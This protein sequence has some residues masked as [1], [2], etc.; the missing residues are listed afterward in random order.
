MNSTTIYSSVIDE[1]TI[2]KTRGFLETA[3]G[4]YKDPAVP[5]VYVNNTGAGSFGAPLGTIYTGTFTL[6]FIV[7]PLD[8]AIVDVSTSL[9][10]GGSPILTTNETNIS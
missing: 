2:I 1:K 3:I 6:P 9:N 10:V 8:S 7:E 4:G 5:V